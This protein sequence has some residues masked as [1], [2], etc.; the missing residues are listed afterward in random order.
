[1]PGAQSPLP[2]KWPRC[3]SAQY[4]SLAHRNSTP[5]SRSA[6]DRGYFCSLANSTS[7][8]LMPRMCRTSCLTSSPLPLPAATSPSTW[9]VCQPHNSSGIS[10]AVAGAAAA[11]AG[12]QH[13]ESGHATEM[14]PSRERDA[15]HVAKAPHQVVR[16]VGFPTTLHTNPAQLNCADVAQQSVEF[17]CRSCFSQ[18]GQPSANLQQQ[19]PLLLCVCPLVPLV[20]VPDA[21]VLGLGLGLAQ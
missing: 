5:P 18:L 6:A 7:S 4:T 19:L 16:G 3:R 12:Q 14:A 11:A 2:P 15:R 8:L 21:T 20:Q 17:G 10:V 13:L 9:H 1:M